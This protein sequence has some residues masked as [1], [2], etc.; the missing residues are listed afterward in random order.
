MKVRRN[1]TVRVSD[2]ERARLE[3]AA[4]SID[5]Q[6]GWTTFLRNA[7]LVVADIIT[8]QQVTV[9]PLS[10]KSFSPDKSDQGDHYS[11]LRD[12]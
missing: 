9:S 2:A 8:K 10:G 11:R 1:R 5:E 3:R 6:I 4:H 7:A 12:G